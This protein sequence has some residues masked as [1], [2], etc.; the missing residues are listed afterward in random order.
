MTEL[1]GVSIIVDN[2]GG[3]NG[4][5]GAEIAAKSA[6]DGYTLLSATASIT[7]DQ[8]GGSSVGARA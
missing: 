3:A 2:R 6:P 4:F 1:L 8:H 5:I 7:L